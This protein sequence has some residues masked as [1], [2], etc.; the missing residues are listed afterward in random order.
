MKKNPISPKYH[1]L[2]H[3]ASDIYLQ[4]DPFQ[5]QDKNEIMTKTNITNTEDHFNESLLTLPNSQQDFLKQSFNMMQPITDRHEY[6][7][8]M[9][10]IPIYEE[11]YG[12]SRLAA[13]D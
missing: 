9:R 13:P 2:A 10:D 7:N 11:K 5:L 8:L 6:D 12:S 1:S 4:E 3:P